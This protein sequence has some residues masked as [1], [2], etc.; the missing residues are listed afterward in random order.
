MALMSGRNDC[1]STTTAVSIQ[2]LVMAT[3]LASTCAST[4]SGK[5]L[6]NGCALDR[7]PTLANL[8]DSPE[9]WW[10][11]QMSEQTLTLRATHGLH[12]FVQKYD[13]PTRLRSYS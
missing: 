2:C 5:C 10:A 6:A 7:H 9:R 1:R 4:V 3:R 8:A 12:G 11:C 13:A